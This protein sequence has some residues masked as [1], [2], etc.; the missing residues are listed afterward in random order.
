MTTTTYVV[1]TD[2]SDEPI[3]ALT[4][5]GVEID[6]IDGTHCRVTVRG[7]RPSGFEQALNMDRHVVSYT[8]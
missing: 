2:G 8:Y 4:Q 5:Y 6:P 7:D 1:E 3:P